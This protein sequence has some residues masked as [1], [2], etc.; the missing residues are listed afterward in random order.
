MSDTDIVEVMVFGDSITYGAWDNNG[1]WVQ[2]L[3]EPMDVKNLVDSSVAYFVYNLGV[4]DDTS[5]GIVKRFEHEVAARRYLNEVQKRVAIFCVGL[6]DSEIILKKKTNRVPPEEFEHNVNE[7]IRMAR[8]HVDKIIFVGP[9]PVDETLA[10]PVPWDTEKAYRNSVI[11]K[12][13]NIVKSI[14]KGEKID[15]I[16]IFDVVIR[17]D[18]KSLLEDGLHPSPTGH[19]VIYELIRGYLEKNKILNFNAT[20]SLEHR[21]KEDK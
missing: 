3:R 20:K 4:V 15:F 16:E 14:C 5:A 1:G 8:E 18:Y 10:E 12:Y 11:K 7:L 21:Y 2:K 13:N 19:F 9:T 17:L 6:N